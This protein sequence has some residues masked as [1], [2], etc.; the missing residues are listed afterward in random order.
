LT[1]PIGESYCGGTC[2]GRKKLMYN[3]FRSLHPLIVLSPRLLCAQHGTAGERIVLFE[4]G[5]AMADKTRGRH[6][7]I[8]PVLVDYSEQW[9]T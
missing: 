4:P 1:A 7:T 6:D 8:A 3:V 9:R 2:A 5:G